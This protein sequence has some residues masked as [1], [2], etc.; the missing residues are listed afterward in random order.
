[1][2]NVRS[3]NFWMLCWLGLALLVL[4]P[5]SASAQRRRQAREEFDDPICKRNEYGICQKFRLGLLGGSLLST[6]GAMGGVGVEAGYTWVI[7]PRFELGGNIVALQDVRFDDGH[8][9]G[10]FEAMA[11]IATLA[12]PYHRVFLQFGL[13]GSFYESSDDSYVAFPAGSGGVTLELGGAGLGIYLTGG[14]SL[15]YAEGLAVLPRAGI[16]LVF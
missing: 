3:R 4:L 13:G 8:Y 15:L 1:M 11:R 16:G 10:T 9:V 6:D 5:E 2:V 12:G 7:A 14:M